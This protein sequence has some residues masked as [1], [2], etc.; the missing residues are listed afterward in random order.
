EEARARARRRRGGAGAAA[1]GGGDDVAA[2]AENG[3]GF[4]ASVG[5][6]WGQVATN[7]SR[8]RWFGTY[9]DGEP[10]YADLAVEVR[11]GGMPGAEGVGAVATSMNPST[12]AEAAA[13]ADVAMRP[14]AQLRVVQ[15][16]M[17]TGRAL[18]KRPRTVAAGD[19]DDGWCVADAGGVCVALPAG[20]VRFDSSE[21][22]RGFGGWFGQECESVKEEDVDPVLLR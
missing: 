13:V 4:A 19:D 11:G 12:R 8:G 6:I 17:A 20:Q 15:M 21:E 7:R 10:D 14:A 2:G 9:A 3:T 22:M 5:R 18:S 1:Q 16:P